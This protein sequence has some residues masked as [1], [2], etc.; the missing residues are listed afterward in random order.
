MNPIR[1]AILDDHSVVRHGLLALFATQ[2]EIEIVGCYPNGRDLLQGLQRCAADV[3]LL[4]YALGEDEIDGVSFIKGIRRKFPQCRILVFS[5][6]Q[7]TA[8]VSLALKVGAHGFFGKGEDMTELPYAIRSVAGGNLYLS[9][10]MAYRISEVS[11]VNITGTEQTA[12]QELLWGSL[13][14]REQEVIRCFLAGMTVTQIAE[15][16]HRSI[17]TI[18]AQKSSAYRKLGVSSDNNLFRLAKDLE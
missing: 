3:V 13:S 15:K 6:Y 17:K 14:A 9:S 7:D 11:E 10:E 12:G 2:R 1:L 5:S 18:S 16:F 4:D 8:T